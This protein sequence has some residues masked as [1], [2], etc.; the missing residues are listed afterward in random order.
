MN[1]K[2]TVRT[3]KLALL[4]LVLLV[5]VGCGSS[6]RGRR[7]HATYKFFAEGDNCAGISYTWT[8]DLGVSA[9]CHERFTEGD[10]LVDCPVPK[11]VHEW[12]EWPDEPS[13][14]IQ[15]SREA[16]CTVRCEIW[17]SGELESSAEDER[18]AGCGVSV[19]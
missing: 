8:T 2:V 16:D 7:T 17:I 5:V 11:T 13:S 19:P 18:I 10:R 9:T 6:Q 14:S 12:V 1:G 4:A 3:V 15:V